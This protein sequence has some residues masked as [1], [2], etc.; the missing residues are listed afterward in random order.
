MQGTAAPGSWRFLQKAAMIQVEDEGSRLP[1]AFQQAAQESWN[2]T[3][4]SN[5]NGKTPYLAPGLCPSHRGAVQQSVVLPWLCRLS[6]SAVAVQGVTE[7]QICSSPWSISQTRLRLY[8][9]SSNFD[10]ASACW[11]N[12][13]GASRPLSSLFLA[14][15][16]VGAQPRGQLC[17]GRGKHTNPAAAASGTPCG[18]VSFFLKEETT[19][20]LRSEV[21]TERTHLGAPLTRKKI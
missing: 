1:C 13:K 11:Y 16:C 17:H 15:C 19:L 14:P 18:L 20:Q 4:T 6:E 5:R 8:R 9:L 3:T 2:I 12:A 7:G 21:N 10:G